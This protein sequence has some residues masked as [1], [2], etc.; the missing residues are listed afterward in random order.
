MSHFWIIIF[1]DL[2]REQLQRS[3]HAHIDRLHAHIDNRLSI[4]GERLLLWGT[5]WPESACLS[6]PFRVLARLTANQN[7]I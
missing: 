4:Q 6:P 7:R 5:V 3:M 1:R 2:G